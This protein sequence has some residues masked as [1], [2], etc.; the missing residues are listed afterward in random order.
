M[1]YLTKLL[2]KKPE[3]AEKHVQFDRPASDVI[4]A[5]EFCARALFHPLEKK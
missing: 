3:N 4:P 5:K 2:F 1:F